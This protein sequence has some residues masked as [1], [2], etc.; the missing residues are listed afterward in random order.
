MRDPRDPRTTRTGR[1]HAL[2]GPSGNMVRID[3][4]TVRR[5]PHTHARALQELRSIHGPPIALAQHALV[6]DAVSH[7]GG[8]MAAAGKR[9]GSHHRKVVRAFEGLERSRDG[10]PASPV[11]PSDPRT[12][13]E[14]RRRQKAA[15]RMFR[16]LPGSAQAFARELAA[17]PPG[18]GPKLMLAEYILAAQALLQCDGI[19]RAAARLLREH[20]ETFAHRL[21]SMERFVV[22][23]DRAR[24]SLET[25]GEEAR[26]SSIHA[27]LAAL[28]T[29]FGVGI[30]AAARHASLAELASTQISEPA[31]APTIS[32]RLGAL[33]GMMTIE[34]AA[35]LLGCSS[36]RSP[37]A[38]DAGPVKS[39]QSLDDIARAIL[40][41]R[42][43]KHRL[44]ELE[45]A[46]V[47]HAYLAA[48]GNVSAA[49]RL[50]GTERKAL[51]RRVAKYEIATRGRGRP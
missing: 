2:Y 21:Q 15:A 16:S 4:D 37:T 14:K 31:S 38:R 35:S 6:L 47:A 33:V 42:D 51:E 23:A 17:L 46:V 8:N 50:V 34:E 22:V 10:A 48:K 25:Q 19:V 43:C 3:R 32:P 5:L 11:R 7:C 26:P 36:T 18:H 24:N 41:L 9:L 39:P 49:A 20:V 30:V 12:R 44:R 29:G 40:G 27:K 45:R 28:A 13:G 1:S